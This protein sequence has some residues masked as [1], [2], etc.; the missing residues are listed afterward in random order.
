MIS[1][2]ATGLGTAPSTDMAAGAIVGAGSEGGT[3]ARSAARAS[4]CSREAAAAYY[5]NYFAS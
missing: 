3:R 5:N 1:G 4:R 2:G